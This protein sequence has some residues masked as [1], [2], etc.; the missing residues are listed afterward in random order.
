MSAETYS[1]AVST[2]IRSGPA[3]DVA[4]ALLLAVIGLVEIWLP[5]DSVFGAGSPVVSSIGVVWFAGHLAFRRVRPRL[6]LA[7]LAVWPI[8]TIAQGGHTQLLFFGQM[9]PLMVLTY[10][11]ARHAPGRLRWLGGVVVGA[12]LLLADL[13]IPELRPPNELIFHW[14]SI[15]LAYLLGHALR[16]AAE[17]A[18]AEAVRAHRAEAASREQ[19]L[20]AVAEER[21]RIARELHDIV[22]H[23]VGV[24]VVQ[25]GSAEQVVE[26]DPE[27]ARRALGAIRST[28]AGALAEMRRLVTMLRDPDTGGELA[29][30]PG[31]GALPDLVEAVR[32]SGLAVDLRVTGERSAL[33]AGLDLT[34]YRIVQEALSNIRKHS[35]A[36]RA[37]VALDFGADALAITVADPGPARVGADADAGAGHGLIGMRERAGLFGGQIETASGEDGFTVRVVLPLEKV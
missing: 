5:M 29:P 17:R 1:D 14:A 3:I 2:R 9:V 25:A 24:I 36:D 11:M 18:A 12:Y 35:R 4:P 32:A 6:A 15:G 31:V 34:A 7:G 20:Q 21:A 26:E 30:Q 28:G 37:D 22:A 27:Y 13:T 16:R 23:S 8:L 10:S 33:P 19:A